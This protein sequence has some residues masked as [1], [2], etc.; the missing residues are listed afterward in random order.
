ML[1]GSV[2]QACLSLSLEKCNLYFFLLFTLLLF[3]IGWR[4]KKKL[5]SYFATAGSNV[6]KL[7]LLT[8]MKIFFKNSWMSLSFLGPLFIISSFS[9]SWIPKS[10][11]FSKCCLQSAS[12]LPAHF[13]PHFHPPCSTS[14]QYVLLTS[15]KNWKSTMYT[16]SGH[17]WLPEVYL[18]FLKSAPS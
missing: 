18:N 11:N 8:L 17:K 10:L 12:F 13:L 2:F 14:I 16:E 4:G 7:Y 6:S 1:V 3:L 5:N 15:A 9:T